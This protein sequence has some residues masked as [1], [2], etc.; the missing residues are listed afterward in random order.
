VLPARCDEIP[1]R[2]RNG[3]ALHDPIVGDRTVHQLAAHGVQRRGGGFEIV[4]DLS[5]AESVIG[6]FVPVALA[7]HGMKHEARLFGT[8]AP[9]RALVDAYAVHRG[10][11]AAERGER[12]ADRSESAAPSDPDA[13]AV[14]VP[15]FELPVPEP[16]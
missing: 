8:L 9:I 10:G 12:M 7:V 14:D 4:L 1:E 5:Q 15:D 11:S 3:E 13:D 6:G 2:F 16:K